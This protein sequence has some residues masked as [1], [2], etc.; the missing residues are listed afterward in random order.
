MQRGMTM[1][2]KVAG[3]FAS[4]HTTCKWPR[5]FN[6]PPVRVECIGQRPRAALTGVGACSAQRKSVSGA[7][8]W[9]SATPPERSLENLPCRSAAQ[10]INMTMR[11]R[12]DAMALAWLTLGC[13]EDVGRQVLDGG[14][15]TRVRV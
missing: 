10:A 4:A 6:H 9:C 7:T 5:T 2:S 13:D 14:G 1:F 11:R 15:W 8:L 3:A 12:V